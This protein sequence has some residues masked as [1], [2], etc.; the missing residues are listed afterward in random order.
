MTQKEI[1][2]TIGEL[3]NDANYYG[4]LG[5]RFLSNSDIVKLVNEPDLYG[6]PIEDSVALL[7]GDYMHKR[8]LQPELVEDIVVVDAAS[9]RNKE[10]TAFVKEHEVE[11]QPRPTFLLK[12][13]AD[14][15]EALAMKIEQNDE[16]VD[17]LQYDK[18]PFEVEEP[19]I[20]EIH[21]YWFK[22]KADRINRRRGFIADLKTTRSLKLFRQNLRTYGYHSQAWIYQKLFGLPVRF[23]VIDKTDGRL[24]VV[25]LKEETLAD[26]ERYVQWGLEKLEMY[27]GPHP[28]DD[29]GQ[30]YEYM[31]L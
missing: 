24:A 26:A 15:I 19:M 2:H 8:I 30:Y 4:E 29:I 10:Y 25:D 12:K 11:G 3:R 18:Q 16:F 17:A 5:R 21:G 20:G 28:T 31:E 23:Y 1:A 6:Q 7:M 9:R 27:Y 22:G 14:E 13:E